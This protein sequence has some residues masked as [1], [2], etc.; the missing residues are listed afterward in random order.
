MV[1]VVLSQLPELYKDYV[2]TDKDDVQILFGG[3]IG[4]AD[5]IGHYITIHYK[6]AE[7]R[8]YIY[9]SLFSKE[10]SDVQEKII[11][12][13][14][15]KAKYLRHVKPKT[16]QPDGSSCGVFAIATATAAI[17]GDDPKK[18]SFKLDGGKNGKDRTMTM[19]NHLK[20]MLLSGK[21]N[22]FPA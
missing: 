16:S 3:A 14:Y 19:R 11:K 5:I 18:T 20:D 15:P 10:L 6:H 8:V 17:L 2:K 21:L 1:D 7:K 13:L 9:D 12:T 4:M 22:K